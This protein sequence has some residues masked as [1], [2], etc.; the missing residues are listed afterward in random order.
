LKFGWHERMVAISQEQLILSYGGPTRN[1]RGQ[2]AGQV[3]SGG[4]SS[5][6][7][8]EEWNTLPLLMKEESDR[9]MFEMPFGR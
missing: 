4:I 8:E 2:N 9:S 6:T 1:V 7:R 3:S 5:G